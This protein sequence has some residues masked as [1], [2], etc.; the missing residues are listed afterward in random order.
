MEADSTH[1]HIYQFNPGMTVRESE[2]HL[3]NNGKLSSLKIVGSL[4]YYVQ[5]SLT[6]DS[7]RHI[8]TIPLEY[9][10]QVYSQAGFSE[11]ESS[12]DYQPIA[13]YALSLRD[14]SY[15]YSD[16]SEPLVFA[17]VGLTP[18]SLHDK[19]VLYGVNLES[20]NMNIFFKKQDDA[21]VQDI[22]VTSD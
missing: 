2:I 16:S 5:E 11:L 6:R 4:I 8:V 19:A 17:A 18:L 13:P 20:E 9:D 10:L 7:S 1:L 22:R 21:A 12:T 15:S 3:S 14:A